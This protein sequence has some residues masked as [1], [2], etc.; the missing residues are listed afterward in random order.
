MTAECIE[1][2]ELKGEAAA[3]LISI[4]KKLASSHP[5][6]VKSAINKLLESKVDQLTEKK[7]QE[8][9]NTIK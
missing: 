6:E 8:I 1:K 9:L 3:A 7:A 2:P 4:G 5:Q